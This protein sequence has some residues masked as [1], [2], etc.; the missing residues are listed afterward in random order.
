M[1][2][3]ELLSKKELAFV[4]TFD[5]HVIPVMTEYVLWRY[6]RSNISDSEM[7]KMLFSVGMSEAEAE[8]Y[9]ID[10]QI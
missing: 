5:A 3:S 4:N 8:D 9:C 1:K 6:F 2:K 7:Y 10:N